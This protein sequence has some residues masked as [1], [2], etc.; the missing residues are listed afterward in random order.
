MSYGYSGGRK[1]V[2]KEC[3]AIYSNTYGKQAHTRHTG[4]RDFKMTKGS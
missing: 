2:C 1:A 4:H 3:G